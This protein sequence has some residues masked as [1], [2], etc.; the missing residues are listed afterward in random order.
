[1]GCDYNPYDYSIL[2][3][4]VFEEIAAAY[5]AY[6]KHMKFVLQNK[7]IINWYGTEYLCPLF[8]FAKKSKTQIAVEQAFYEEHKDLLSYEPFPYYFEHIY[9]PM[10]QELID[11]RNKLRSE[12]S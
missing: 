12:I 6:E 1:M 4:E 3:E 10:T 8:E 5:E 9:P 11:M 2:P 7:R